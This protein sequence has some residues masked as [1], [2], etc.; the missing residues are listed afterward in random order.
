MNKLIKELAIT[1]LALATFSATS[2]TASAHFRLHQPV[3]KSLRGTWYSKK[4]LSKN[5][6]VKFTRNT[7]T[8]W[9]GKYKEIGSNKV[10]K[11]NQQQGNTFIGKLWMENEKHG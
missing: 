6:E 4:S 2:T 5:S 7:F 1:G 11:N 8:T 10:T 9:S 3:P